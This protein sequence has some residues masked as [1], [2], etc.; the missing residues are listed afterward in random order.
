MKSKVT[1]NE[2]VRIFELTDNI[3]GSSE[4]D[5]WVEELQE[6]IVTLIFD[7]PDYVNR[8]RNLGL[9]MTTMPEVDDDKQ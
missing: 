6:A 5:E 2:L 8:L 3:F 4:P 7:N 1:N 9:I